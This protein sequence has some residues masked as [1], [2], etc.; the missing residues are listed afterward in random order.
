MG[1]TLQ[2]V[3]RS[4]FQGGS[5][6]SLAF[7]SA[8]SFGVEA[9]VRGLIRPKVP[10]YAIRRLPLEDYDVRAFS[11]VIYPQPGAPVTLQE[12]IMETLQRIAPGWTFS[13]KEFSVMRKEM[14]DQVMTPFSVMMLIAVFLIL[15]VGFGLFGVLW[16]SVTRRTSELGLRRAMG[17]SRQRIYR[18]I[19][20]EMCLAAGIALVIGVLIAVQFPI[21][22]T[23]DLLDWPVAIGGML[24]SG[25][26]ILSLCFLCA[27]YP[28]WLASR[29][30]PAAALHYE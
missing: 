24:I 25:T 14:I 2:T 17:A 28:G 18:Q 22:G 16:Q 29:R 9:E 27:L 10:N 12:E 11:L 5:T 30:A 3:H 19:V 6:R 13:I 26:L 1:T 20:A 21:L 4:N 15:M 7:V 8:T 23:F